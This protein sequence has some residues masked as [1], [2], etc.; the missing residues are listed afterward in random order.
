MHLIGSFVMC[1]PRHSGKNSKVVKI[2]EE[3]EKLITPL[4][5][6]AK[7]GVDTEDKVKES[8]SAMISFSFF[9][10]PSSF[11]SFFLL[12]LLLLLL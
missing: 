3:A 11:F 9:L 4:E 6:I 7:F 10:S 2:F 12:L 1:S 8:T 5:V